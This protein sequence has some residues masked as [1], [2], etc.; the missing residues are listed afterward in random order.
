MQ[1]QDDDAHAH[2][3]GHFNLSIKELEDELSTFYR[4]C[5]VM[6]LTLF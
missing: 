1:T 3:P 4:L 5:F 2:H 6:F